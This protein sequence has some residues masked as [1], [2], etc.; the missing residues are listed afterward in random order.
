[1]KIGD[2]V[3]ENVRHSGLLGVVVSTTP[4]TELDV[5]MATVAWDNGSAGTLSPF[6][7]EVISENR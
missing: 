7:L 6:L 1:M 2:L 3:V 5:E 4:E